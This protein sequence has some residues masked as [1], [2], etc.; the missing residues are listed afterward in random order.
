MLK[1]LAFAAMLSTLAYGV[2]AEEL[3]W[4]GG[5]DELNA[6]LNLSVPGSIET[7][8]LSFWCLPDID[9]V[10]VAYAFRPAEAKD[11]ALVDIELSA[12]G[13]TLPQVQTSAVEIENDHSFVL[14]GQILFSEQFVALISSPGTLTIRAEGKA[15][16]FSLEGAKEA[17]VPLLKMCKARAQ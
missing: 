10:Y 13:I 8:P 4:S 12:G 6:V 3:A 7:I 5:G 9:V 17:A 2:S 15:A 11:G 1:R 16:E 14:E